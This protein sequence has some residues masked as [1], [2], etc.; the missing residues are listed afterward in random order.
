MQ[1][2]WRHEFNPWVGKIPWRRKWQPSPVFLHGKPHGQRS[3]VGYSPWG[4]QRVGH[5]Q[6]SKQQEDSNPLCSKGLQGDLKVTG[7]QGQFWT[8]HGAWKSAISWALL[9]RP[10]SGSWGEQ[11]GCKW[12]LKELFHWKVCLSGQLQTCFGIRQK[13]PLFLLCYWPLY[14][15]KALWCW[16]QWLEELQYGGRD[17]S[18]KKKV[19]ST[20]RAKTIGHLHATNE[21]WLRL[22]P[23]CISWLKV[24]IDLKAKSKK[25]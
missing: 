17:W 3:L 5:N 10:T 8:Q 12:K 14:M 25:F 22:C 24:K 2:M 13:R 9:S 21:A 7:G 16:H 18:M 20:N 11:K 1:E 19:F 23:M 15:E 4:S 6:M